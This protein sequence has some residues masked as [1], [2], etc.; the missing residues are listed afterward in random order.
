MEVG[1]K[2]T[3]WCHSVCPTHVLTCTSVSSVKMCSPRTL[4]NLTMALFRKGP[5]GR[6]LS[7]LGR[8]I[9]A[10]ARRSPCVH[11]WA[12]TSETTKRETVNMSWQGAAEGGGVVS[13]L[14]SHLSSFRN[15]STEHIQRRQRFS[16]EGNRDSEHRC[17]LHGWGVFIHGWGLQFPLKCT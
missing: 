6:S 9:P 7:W 16:H 15:G 5:L 11:H 8:S 4:Q 3:Q 1:G 14:N 12:T 17:S 10:T 2:L 13:V